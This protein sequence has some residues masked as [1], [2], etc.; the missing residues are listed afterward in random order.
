MEWTCCLPKNCGEC[1]QATLSLYKM[2]R[3]IPW[4][5]MD[6]KQVAKVQ[7]KNK[8][9]NGKEREREW[10][11]NLGNFQKWTRNKLTNCFNDSLP[12]MFAPST[13]TVLVSFALCYFNWCFS[14]YM[15]YQKIHE[16]IFAV[17]WLLHRFQQQQW[18]PIRVH[19]IVVL[20][21]KCS[22]G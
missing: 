1:I 20:V 8:T 21:I 16:N 17:G 18:Q 6:G 12:K 22:T 2:I 3:I 4:A 14:C 15:R 11:K 10:K 13:F 19:I 5:S 7:K 9:K